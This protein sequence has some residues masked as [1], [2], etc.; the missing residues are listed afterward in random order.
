MAAKNALTELLKK[1]EAKFERIELPQAVAVKVAECNAAVDG[2]N[3]LNRTRCAKEA[4]VEAKALEVAA[5][6]SL[7]TGCCLMIELWH[8]FVQFAMDRTAS[9]FQCSAMSDCFE[10]SCPQR[11]GCDLAAFIIYNA[12]HSDLE[13]S[14]RSLSV[15]RQGIDGSAVVEPLCATHC[16]NI[17][18]SLGEGAATRGS[19]RA[20][21]RIR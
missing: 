4:E 11:D 2:E 19:L 13:H 3:A 14:E 15:L 17:W 18:E 20:S 5:L 12:Q 6:E 7:S 21:G 8:C 10:R 1:Y 16:L 9:M